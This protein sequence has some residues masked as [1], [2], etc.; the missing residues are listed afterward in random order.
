MPLMVAPTLLVAL[1]ASVVADGALDCAEAEA[2]A[3]AK[4]R[5]RT[6][7]RAAVR[8]IPARQRAA[9]EQRLAM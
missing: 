5:H 2:E 6:R 9:A 1:A 8:T 7:L 3:A 4:T